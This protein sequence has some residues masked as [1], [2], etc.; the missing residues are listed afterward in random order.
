MNIELVIT[1][2]ITAI[3]STGLWRFVEYMFTRKDNRKEKEDLARARQDSVN[4]A[5]LHHLIYEMCETAISRGKIF[6]SELDDLEHLAEPYF[7]L[8]GNGTGRLLVEEARKLPKEL[9]TPIDT[10]YELR[11]KNEN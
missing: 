6:V 5:L 3:G 9:G 1:V 8:G 10:K 2:A 4:L 11:G 7:S